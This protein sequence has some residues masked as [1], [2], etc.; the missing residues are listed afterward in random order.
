MA[1]LVN[2][3]TLFGY[4]Y[5]LKSIKSD[6]NMTYLGDFVVEGEE[7]ISVPLAIMGKMMF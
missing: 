7:I 6:R 2:L 3:V 1:H 4:Y 5:L